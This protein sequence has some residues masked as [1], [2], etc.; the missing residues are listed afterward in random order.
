MKTKE[1]VKEW[2][3]GTGNLRQPEYTT[4]PVTPPV[5]T[6]GYTPIN[7]GDTDKDTHKELSVPVAD[8]ANDHGI[9]ESTPEEKAAASEEMYAKYGDAINGYLSGIGAHQGGAGNSAAGW[10]TSSREEAEAAMAAGATVNYNEETGKYDITGSPRTV[11]PGTSGADEALLTDGAYAAV[12]HL[13]QQ[14]AAAQTLYQQAVNSG[15]TALADQYRAQ[16]DA[17]HLEAEQIRAR[18]GYLGG[19]DGSG[20]FT[21]GELGLAGGGEEEGR[22]EETLSPLSGIRSALEGWK[23][24]ALEQSNGRIDYAVARA[25][26][27]LERALEDS[28]AQYREQQESVYRDELQALDNSALYAE[29][30]GDRGGIGHSQY[31]AIQAAAAQNRLAVR[32]AQTLLATDTARQIADLRAQGEFEKADKALEITQTYLSRLVELEQWGAEFG[33]DSAK[34]RASLDQWAAEYALAL[35][36]FDLETELS[37]ASLTGTLSDG[38]LTLSGQKQLAQLGQAMLEQGLMPDGS[39]LAAMGMTAEQAAALLAAAREEEKKSTSSSDPDSA[40]EEGEEALTTRQALTMLFEDAYMNGGEVYLTN[41]NAYKDYGF[42]SRSGLALKYRQ[43]LVEQY[44]VFGRRVDFD[45]LVAA[46][47]G[48]IPGRSRDADTIRADLRQRGFS[49]HM[50]DGI[51]K[52]MGK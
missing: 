33:L 11:R 13:Q 10:Q 26:T 48:D 18:A 25:I 15:N 20:Y 4:Q 32:Q 45:E 43:W 37:Y 1:Q 6:M 2:K 5:S 31:N 36:E 52:A 30:R 22:G 23:Q 28:E 47:A 16:M 34:F 50:I 51:L 17:L 21:L 49:D 44:P 29:A 14:Y 8:Y 12:Q 38:T 27:E 41:T 42:T 7:A 46:V 35:R 39:Q 19:E 3:V 40:P 24:A 9:R